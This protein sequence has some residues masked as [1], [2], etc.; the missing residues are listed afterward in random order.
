M[1]ASKGE[2]YGNNLINDY[3]RCLFYRCC[4]GRHTKKSSIS[5]E[6]R[7]NGKTYFSYQ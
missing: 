1:N 7:I 4:G 3:D 6:K 2:K 5:P